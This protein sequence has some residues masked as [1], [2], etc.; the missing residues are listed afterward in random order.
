MQMCTLLG[1]TVLTGVINGAFSIVYLLQIRALTP[2][3]FGPAAGVLLAQ[4]TVMMAGILAE[5]HVARKRLH[6]AAELNGLI[7]RL[8]SGIQKIKLAGAE[9]RAFSKWARR[10]AENAALL[11]NPPPLLR[12]QPAL[13]ALIA[14]GEIG[15]AHV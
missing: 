1:D 12:I 8:F 9:Q 15:R 14:L 5:T 11:Y 7:F 3:L 13:S 4:L 6:I 2:A 10:Y